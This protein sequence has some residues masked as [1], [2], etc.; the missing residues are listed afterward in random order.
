M[1]RICKS[2]RYHHLT[3]WAT[4]DWFVDPNARNPI[5]HQWNME[6]QRQMSQNLAAS[7]GYAGSSSYRLSYTTITNVADAGVGD[8]A[9]RKPFPYARTPWFMTDQGH[10]NYHSFRLKVER[11][12]TDGVGALL[13][14]TWSK[15][16]DNG[17]SGFYSVESSIS[18][19]RAAIQNKFDPNSNRA[20][21]RLRCSSHALPRNYVGASLRE[22]EE[23][24]EQRSGGMDSGRLANEHDRSGSHRSAYQH[25]R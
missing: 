5:S 7:I 2:R 14:Y 13:A 12:F 20:P 25:G 3:P 8:P 19:S 10:S 9:L 1:S 4:R 21:M 24:P 18:G 6:L 16:L 17:S 22:G 11:R 15:C 23:V